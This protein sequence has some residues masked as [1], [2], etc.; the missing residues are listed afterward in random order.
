MPVLYHKSSSR[1]KIANVSLFTTISHTQFIIPKENLLRL[2]NQTIAKQVLRTKSCYISR[3][4]HGPTRV[5][6]AN[7]ISTALAVYRAY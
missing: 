7:G 6:D 1:H 5:V 2:A 4:F 3:C